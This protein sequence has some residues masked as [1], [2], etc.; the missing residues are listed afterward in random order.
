MVKFEK[1]IKELGL[2]QCKINL[3]DKEVS[4][5]IAKNS[6]AKFNLAKIAYSTDDVRELKPVTTNPSQTPVTLKA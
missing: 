3:K 1:D 6:I 2:V 5:V 4:F